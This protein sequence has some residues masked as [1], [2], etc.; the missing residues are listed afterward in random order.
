MFGLTFGSYLAGINLIPM[1]CG[2]R[3][4]HVRVQRMLIDTAPHSTVYSDRENTS[5]HTTATLI[6]ACTSPGRRKIGQV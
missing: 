3:N 1:E 2:V 5:L 4:L 6:T